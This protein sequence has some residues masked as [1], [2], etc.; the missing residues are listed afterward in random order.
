MNL[1]LQ[2]H[3]RLGEEHSASYAL[4]PGDLQRVDRVKT[5]LEKPV[6]VA[7]NREFKSIL[8]FYKGIKILV[9]STGI[10]GPSTAIA[11]EEL[12]NIGVNTLIRIGSCGALQSNIKL[13]D[14]ILAT[15]AVRN[16][17]SSKSYIESSYPA[18][19]NINVLT[20]IINTASELRYQYH[21][22]IIRSHD[23]FYTDNEQAID[24]F[25]TNNGVLA[26]DME[27]ASLM[28]I[29]SL[30]GLKTASI[31]NVVVE[32]NYALEDGINSYVDGEDET[33][34]GEEKEIILA[35]ESIVKL[36]SLKNK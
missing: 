29:G 25:W 17:G 20:S 24:S 6:E 34:K 22:G 15:G 30:R 28:V 16:D 18:V 27:S 5:F 12:K 13:G 31:L 14:L 11:V 8:G 2:P 35:L 23:S 3:I 32:N 9:T 7:F 21:C 26:S 10:G 33:S 1:T 4:L 36:D 19:P